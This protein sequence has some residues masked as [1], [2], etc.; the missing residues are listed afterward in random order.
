MLP[1]G[2]PSIQQASHPLPTHVVHVQRGPRWPGQ[3]KTQRGAGVEGIREA[4][5]EPE[6]RWQGAPRFRHA[7]RAVHLEDVDLGGRG[8]RVPVHLAQGP[9]PDV[10]A[11]LGLEPGVLRLGRVPPVPVCHRHTPVVRVQG[12]VDFVLVDAPVRAVVP[13]RVLQT[14]HQHGVVHVDLDLVRGE[15]GVR[16]VLRVPDGLGV[17]VNRVRGGRV[18][19]GPLLAVAVVNRELALVHVGHLGRLVRGVARHPYG[20]HVHL[21]APLQRRVRNIRHDFVARL[22]APVVHNRQAVQLAGGR[23]IRVARGDHQE[24]RVGPRQIESES[25]VRGVQFEFHRLVV[26]RAVGPAPE[27]RHGGAPLEDEVVTQT[28]PVRHHSQGILSDAHL[29]LQVIPFA[30][31]HLELEHQLGL[32]ALAHVVELGAHPVPERDP[33]RNVHPAP[34]HPLPAPGVERDQRPPLPV[35]HVH[36]PVAGDVD[37]VGD[38]S[39]AVEIVAHA[40]V[41]AG[42]GHGVVELRAPLVQNVLPALVEVVGDLAEL[43]VGNGQSR[44]RNAALPDAAVAPVVVQPPLQVA[45]FFRRGDVDEIVVLQPIVQGV[46]PRVVALH[47]AVLRVVVRRV[48]RPTVLARVGLASVDHRIGDS[49]V[50]RQL[51]AAR[52]AVRRHEGVVRGVDVLREK[53]GH[54]AVEVQLVREHVADLRGRA[55]GTAGLHENGTH[56]NGSHV[57]HPWRQGVARRLQPLQRLQHLTVRN[58]VAVLGQAVVVHVPGIPVRVGVEISSLGQD[59]RILP[60]Q[61]QCGRQKNDR[62]SEKGE[63][64]HGVSFPP[65]SSFCSV[66]QHDATGL[67]GAG[68][69]ARRLFRASWRQGP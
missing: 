59:G 37:V 6:P 52:V 67:Q 30:V 40:V 41:V 23:R 64:S 22:T 10:A 28:L 19:G 7:G 69:R 56:V 46:V 20:E 18:F 16:R 68:R 12:D 45:Q 44:A 55:A 32:V 33:V 54:V 34:V 58:D 63:T 65:D 8:P 27:H 50:D 47:P 13:R 48:H 49:R 43:R 38:L 11:P 2:E 60:R 31:G 26:E 25:Q 4:R 9:Q 66:P 57:F 5:V 53:A 36:A 14:G 21:A 61:G 62:K 1:C 24:E 42:P 35:Q 39:V 29:Q 15:I 3:V 17:A 51:G